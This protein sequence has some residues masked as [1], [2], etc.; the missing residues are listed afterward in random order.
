M[1]KQ[2]TVVF[3]NVGQMYFPQTRV[4]CHYS[5]TCDHQWSSCD[6]IGIFEEGWSSVR[7]YHT[8][9][10]A[11]AP[12][13]Y[14]EGTNANCCVLFQASYLPRPS[15]AQ[16]QFVYVD[17][18]G[19]VCGESRLFSFC[20]PKPLEE[21][22]TLK[23]E[24][25][26]ED[27]EEDL[28]L[29]IPRAQLLQSQLE[30][31]LKQQAD[32]QHGLDVAKKE[33]ETENERSKKERME[34]E[35]EREAMKDEISELRQTVR[36][37]SKMLTK[38]E[39]KHNDVMYSQES[40]TSKMSN[41]LAEK[42]KS[43]QRIRELEDNI[44]VLTA[45]EVE[46]NTELQRLKD[47]VKKVSGQMKHEEEKRKCVQVTDSHPSN[48]LSVLHRLSKTAPVDS[49]KV[50]KDAA[51]EEVRGLQER[52]EVSEHAAESLRREVRELGTR[53]NHTHA[54]LHQAWL[55]VGQLTL[56]L[57]EENL[58][59]REE[60]ANWTLEREASKHT[61]EIEKKKLQELSSEVQRL[62]GWLQE[63]R[64]ER[65]RVEVEHCRERDYNRVLLSD[66]KRELQELKARLKRSRASSEE[67]LDQQDVMTD[68]SQSE[69]RSDGDVSTSMSAP[70]SV[71]LPSVTQ[72]E[73]DNLPETHIHS[74]EDEVE[75]V[76]HCE[77]RAFD[78][79]QMMLQEVVDP[80]LSEL[81]DS[82]M[83]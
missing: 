79:K 47:R 18:M 11:L 19:E 68:I 3:R 72:L 13:G 58:L 20:A 63:E 1:D 9:T 5:L 49:R 74:K 10:W 53:L 59:L 55:Q 25:D 33:M 15:A 35:S 51:V 23:E 31:C 4:E 17:K 81:A 30:E 65:E 39:G 57:S 80:V 46:E 16:Y 50:E 8:Y 44:K 48:A 73:Q 45:R 82:P 69:Q 27:G 29:V 56:Q 21:L 67:Q 83:W 60:R 37:K 12:D 75:D 6:W 76:R 7:Q 62:E 32:L 61:A 78:G 28:L 70:T 77:P 2:A 14:T 42:E 24:R 41:L 43:Q 38:I 36:Q 40:L 52:L 71:R 22:E 26:E 54:E 66:A 64:A 34:W